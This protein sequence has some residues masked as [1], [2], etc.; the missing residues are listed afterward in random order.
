M[1]KGIDIVVVGLQPWDIEIGSNCKNI[2]REFAKH[3]RV[4]YVNPPLD[5]STAMRDKKNPKVEKRI[6]VIRG[7]QNDITEVE[8]NLWNLTPR[9]YAESIN[10]IPSTSAFQFFN[11]IN[12]YRLA[13]SINDATKRLGFQKFVLFN[14]QSMIRCYHLKEMIKPEL[15]I[16]YIRDNL[17]TIP[18]FK[19]HALKMEET[20]IASADAVATNSDFLAEYAKKFNPHS[21]MVTRTQSLLSIWQSD[22]STPPRARAKLRRFRRRHGQ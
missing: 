21:A 5:R 16:Y 9:V 2:A 6:A 15:F 19:K 7:K 20:L 3:N 1:I 11:R 13:K 22:L 12:N 10:W 14:D 4:L 17:S 18:Y 8:T